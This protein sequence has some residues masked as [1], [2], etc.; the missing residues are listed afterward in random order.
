MI[1][2]SPP[3]ARESTPRR[4]HTTQTP[5]SANNTAWL[6]A[7]MSTKCDLTFSPRPVR[8]PVSSQ[9]AGRQPPASLGK[10]LRNPTQHCLG[11][12]PSEV[13]AATC[14]QPCSHRTWPR[15]T[16]MCTPPQS[17]APS[18]AKAAEARGFGRCTMPGHRRPTRAAQRASKR[19]P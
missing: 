14:A 2:H 19:H 18:P 11:H 13:Q 9:H 10:R 6:Q 3:R 5:A 17:Q 1:S 15:P 8:A 7:A 12:S 4:H 16:P